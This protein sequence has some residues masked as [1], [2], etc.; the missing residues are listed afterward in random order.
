MPPTSPDRLVAWSRMNADLNDTI[1]PIFAS[2]PRSAPAGNH[3][4][5][6]SSGVRRKL[7]RRGT[8]PHRVQS[9]NEEEEG[10][11]SGDYDDPVFEMIRIKVSFHLLFS[12]YL[13][14]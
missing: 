2:G 5:S 3:G 4:R 9:S 11:A 7:T 10:Y 12:R 8:R 1:S 6:P 13:S 14:V